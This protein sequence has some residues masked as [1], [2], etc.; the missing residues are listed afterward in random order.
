MTEMED[1]EMSLDDFRQWMVEILNFEV[2]S[3]ERGLHVITDY[4]IVKRIN[5]YYGFSTYCYIFFSN[6]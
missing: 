3:E 1:T 6:L 4:I 5:F 2:I